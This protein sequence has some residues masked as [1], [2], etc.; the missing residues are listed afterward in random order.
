MKRSE[1]MPE[2]IVRSIGIVLQS[3]LKRSPGEARCEWSKGGTGVEHAT[4]IDAKTR[5]REDAL[6]AMQRLH[7]HPRERVS[8]LMVA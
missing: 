7:T 6:T 8:N 2:K 5:G 1:L 4:D 3:A